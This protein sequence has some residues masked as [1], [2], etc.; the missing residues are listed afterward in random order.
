MNDCS[1]SSRRRANY[2]IISEYRVHLK[3][4]GICQFSRLLKSAQR[5][6]LSVRVSDPQQSWK[7]KKL[8]P[9]QAGEDSR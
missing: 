6:D 4:I 1:C 7:E 8:P 9:P 5:T 2:G 3:D